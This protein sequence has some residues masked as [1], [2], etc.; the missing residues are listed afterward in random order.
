VAAAG[1]LVRLVYGGGY[2]DYDPMWALVWGGQIADGHL[3]DFEA[4]ATAPTPH[5]LANVVSAMLAPLG[6]EP[7]RVA[8]TWLS[9]LSLGA[10]VIGCFVL[11]ERLMS[12]A[13]GVLFATLVATRSLVVGETLWAGVD[14]PF[15]ALVVWAGALEAARPRRGGAVFG[16]LALA[17]LLR[18]EAWLLAGAYWLYL[19]PSRDSRER[20]RG[21][22]WVLAAPLAWS[23]MDLVA[24]GDPLH[25]LHGTQELGAL[26]ERPRDFDTAIEAMPSY[27]EF[28]VGEEVAIGG[29][30]GA[31][32]GLYLAYERSVVP[33]AVMTLGLITFL[34]LGLLELPL[35]VRYLF[36]PALVLALFCS[37]ALTAWLDPRRGRWTRV[38]LGLA[39]APLALALALAAPD[40][41][42]RLERVA[43]GAE[44]A[45]AAQA[46]LRDLLDAPGAAAGV[47]GCLPAH[48]EH[49]QLRPQVAWFADVDPADL[50]VA[51]IRP[52]ERTAAIV[53]PGAPVATA[54][55]RVGSAPTVELRSRC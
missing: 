18:P 50:V 19:L 52:D 11:G 9:S 48:V 25:S 33:F 36:P 8:V 17:G 20:A 15:L 44:A 6:A 43:R 30:A 3:P 39:A 31:L 42:K 47:R 45:A 26:L 5:P 46:D 14:V 53:R 10:L 27:L 13:V 4:V 12:P 29:L 34:L 49:Y 55:P 16:L 2:L 32:G 28:I 54:L 37:F 35:I 7:A 22:V 24:T 51:P 1:L 21:A 41:R 40:Q 38:A 23:M